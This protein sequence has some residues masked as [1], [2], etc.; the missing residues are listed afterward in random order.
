MFTSLLLFHL[1]DLGVLLLEMFY[2]LLFLHLLQSGLEKGGSLDTQGL[3]REVRDL[4]VVAAIITAFAN[5][6]V[7]LDIVVGG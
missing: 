5:F 2:G 6:S 1:L 7:A 4:S 3:Q